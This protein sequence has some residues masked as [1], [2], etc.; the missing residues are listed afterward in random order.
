MLSLGLTLILIVFCL[1]HGFSQKYLKP[2]LVLPYGISIFMIS[3]A[4]IAQQNFPRLG[5]HFSA[6]ILFGV[7]IFFPILVQRISFMPEFARALLAVLSLW[8][9]VELS[10]LPAINVADVSFAYLTGLAVLIVIFG[11]ERTGLKRD[12]GYKFSYTWKDAGTIVFPFALFLVLV[13]PVGLA[14]RFLVWGVASITPVG[15][16]MLFLSQYFTTALPEEILFR[17]VLQN[18]LQSN[19][20]EKSGYILAAAIFGLAHVN[21][22]SLNYAVPNWHYVFFALI[23]GLLYGY[24]WNRTGKV[25]ISAIA[26]AMVNFLWLIFFSGRPF[27]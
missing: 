13:I 16:L 21:N 22:V 19:L 7:Y 8:L 15:L 10:L 5:D 25:T 18:L 1:V 9:P 6:A 12:L 23:A 26:H 24:I 27:F 20:T 17:G 4:V 2:E 14:V 11:S 3:I